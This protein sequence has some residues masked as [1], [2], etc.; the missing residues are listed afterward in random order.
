M[1][2]Q[3]FVLIE[4]AKAHVMTPEER[5]EQRISF[6]YGNAHLANDAITREHIR[7][8]AARV[9]AAKANELRT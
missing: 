9:D 2:P 1:D 5:A 6:A 4:K 3:L 8:A 7:E